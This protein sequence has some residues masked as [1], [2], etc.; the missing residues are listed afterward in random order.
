MYGC[1]LH[2]SNFFSLSLLE[3]V[4]EVDNAQVNWSAPNL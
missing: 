1:S 4:E 3:A 2:T